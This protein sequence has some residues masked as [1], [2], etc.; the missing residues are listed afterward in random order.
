M[1][2][3]FLSSHGTMA[4]GMKRSVELLSGKNDR[5]TVFDAYVDNCRLE[6]ALDDFFAHSKKED[7]KI[8]LSDLYGGS[9]NQKM[10]LY[11]DRPNTWLIAGVNLALVLELALQEKVQEE[12]LES[13]VEESRKLLKLVKLSEVKPET[14]D[15]FL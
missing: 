8:L 1:L 4:S 12:E 2:K 10:A 14:D 9:V 7:Q 15:D 6:D 13:L 11:L 3:L 5:L